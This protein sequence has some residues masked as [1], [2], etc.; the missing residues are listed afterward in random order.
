MSR[1]RQRWCSFWG[2]ALSG[3]EGRWAALLRRN[4]PRNQSQPETFPPAGLGG[5]GG[6]ALP[7]ALEKAA[8]CTEKGSDASR[9]IATLH[10]TPTQGSLRTNL[11]RSDVLCLSA[12]DQG[13][14]ISLS[15]TAGAV[16]GAR[17][18]FSSLESCR[19]HIKSEL[20]ETSLPSSWDRHTYTIIYSD[21][22]I[23]VWW[24]VLCVA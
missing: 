2:K 6:L 1:G 8:I 24:T 20:K 13:I 15:P 7:L 14:A 22:V 18:L 3:L 21:R 16:L 5:F 4:V 19:A 11:V 12:E 23:T 17:G 10:I 9:R